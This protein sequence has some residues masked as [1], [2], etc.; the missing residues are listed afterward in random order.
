MKATDAA[1]W[2]LAMESEMD[3][4]CAN[5]T[6]DLVKL[7]WNRKALPC[8]WVYRLKQVPDSSGPKYKAHIVTK[9]FR[10]EHGV[11]FDKVFSP[12]VNLP[13]LSF[14]L[15]VVALEDLALLQLEVKTTFLH[16]DLDEEI[17]MEQPQGF[18][19]PGCKHLVCQLWKS[20]YGLKQAP[21]QWYRKFDDFV[22][23][24]GFFRS[25]EDHC[26]Y[27]KDA[28]NGSPIF[29]I[30]YVDDMLLSG[31]NI[32]D[33]AELRRHMLLKFAMNDLGP[34]HHILGMKITRNC[35]SRQLCLSQSNYIR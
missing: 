29:L 14:L 10:Q 8:I 19:S 9:G 17:Y 28:P 25:D 4:I 31:R 26:F 1:S 3:S 11:D 20:L 32:G 2:R 22:R 6:W 12:I 34:V 23:S 16:D 35:Q 27:S 7:S 21:R 5:G 24:L 15:G 33:F 30:L 18:A 13:T